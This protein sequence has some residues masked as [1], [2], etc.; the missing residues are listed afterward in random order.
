MLNGYPLFLFQLRVRHFYRNIYW[1]IKIFLS[2]IVIV[3]GIY[4]YAR[5]NAQ[6][7]EFNQR[8]IKGILACTI[9]Q[10]PPTLFFLAYV[11][12]LLR[13]RCC[14]GLDDTASYFRTEKFLHGH[15]A[16]LAPF[17][18]LLSLIIAL[19]NVN[20]LAD[21]KASGIC[22]DY[23]DAINEPT[24]F[25]ASLYISIVATVLGFGFFVLF[26]LAILC[27][28]LY[29]QSTR[30]REDY[31]DRFL[32]AIRTLNGALVLASVIRL[33]Y[34]YRSNR[35]EDGVGT[36][37]TQLYIATTALALLTFVCF[38]VPY[39]FFKNIDILQAADHPLYRL[40]S[41]PWSSTSTSVPLT[42]LVLSQA[43]GVGVLAT[44]IHF[45]ADFIHSTLASACMYYSIVVWILELCATGFVFIQMLM[46][47]LIVESFLEGLC[48]GVRRERR[49]CLAC[50][51]D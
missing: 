43:M 44:C 42:L 8:A 11:L 1:P 5:G 38:L 2:C 26:D 23:K 34:E 30:R 50:L 51:C 48:P 28:Q 6:E 12:S 45:R 17:L 24:G 47:L 14:E 16:A 36:L 49:G 7:N 13:M 21:M 9:L 40:W 41:A 25:V 19:L 15:R 22:H 33:S 39:L 29:L 37:G 35:Y 46:C 3:S 4:A 18:D 32:L 27:Y 10:L 31:S 20:I